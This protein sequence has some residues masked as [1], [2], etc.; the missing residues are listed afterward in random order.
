MREHKDGSQFRGVALIV[1]E[2]GKFSVRLI[3]QKLPVLR[4][5]DG[6]GSYASRDQAFEAADALVRRRGHDCTTE[7][8]GWVEP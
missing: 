2:P 3:E 1:G 8:T 5:H 4:S 7:C 6:A